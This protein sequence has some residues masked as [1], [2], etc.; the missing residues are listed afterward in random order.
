MWG[1]RVEIVDGVVGGILL[2]GWFSSKDFMMDMR[3]LVMGIFC[4]RGF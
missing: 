2:R 3:E 1:G 4:G